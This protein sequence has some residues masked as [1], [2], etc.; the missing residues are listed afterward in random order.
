[1]GTALY[2][3]SKV[4]FPLQIT[5]FGLFGCLDEQNRGVFAFTSFATAVILLPFIYLFP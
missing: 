2:H 3:M 5:L 4:S 1:M